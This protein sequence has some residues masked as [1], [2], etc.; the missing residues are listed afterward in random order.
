MEV[1]ICGRVL[2]GKAAGLDKHT[3]IW[4]YFYCDFFVYYCVQ[5]NG[6]LGSISICSII[7]PSARF[8]Q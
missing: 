2:V 3:F 7:T 1:E 4:V 5:H 8:R 6:S